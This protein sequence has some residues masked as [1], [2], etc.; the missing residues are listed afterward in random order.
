MADSTTPVLDLT[1]LVERPFIL[2]DREK[3]ELVAAGE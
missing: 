2:I 3:Y 1:T